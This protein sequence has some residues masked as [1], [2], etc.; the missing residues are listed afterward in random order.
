MIL[1]AGRAAKPVLPLGVVLP[2]GLRAPGLRDVQRHGRR[3]EAVRR[4]HQ[5]LGGGR[6]A[7]ADRRRTFPLAEAAQAEQFLEDNTVGGAGT[8]TGKVVI[9]ID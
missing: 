1:M 8:L 4:R 3:A 7:Q 5:P 2:P 6:P 9:T